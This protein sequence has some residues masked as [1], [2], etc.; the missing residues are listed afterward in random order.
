MK[1][2]VN[3]KF[4]ILHSQERDAFVS[5]CDKI[6]REIQQT[7]EIEIPQEIVSVLQSLGGWSGTLELVVSVSGRSTIN[8][9]DTEVKNAI[10]S[11]KN[12]SR[13]RWWFILP[14]S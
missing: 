8:L 6:E 2:N 12:P 3:V 5:G 9:K 11:N 7:V 10:V 1:S 13:K 4:V 14:R